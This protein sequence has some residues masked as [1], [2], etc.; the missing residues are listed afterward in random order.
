MLRVIYASRLISL[1]IFPYPKDQRVSD[2][3]VGYTVNLLTEFISVV[4]CINSTWYTISLSYN[5]SFLVIEWWKNFNILIGLSSHLRK[6]STKT[7]LTKSEVGQ[8]E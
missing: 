5:W 6:T 2:F 7:F 4:N 1:C 8:G 3:L